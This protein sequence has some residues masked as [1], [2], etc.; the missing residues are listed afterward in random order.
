[1]RRK[2]KKRVKKGK[3]ILILLIIAAVFIAGYYIIT[4]RPLLEEYVNEELA[5]NVNLIINQTTSKKIEENNITYDKLISISKDN[6]GRIM[7][8]STQVNEMNKL[9]LDIEKEL[10]ETFL[11]TD[12]ITIE[13]PIG[14][15]LGGEFLSGRGP[16][17]KVRAVPMT[18]VYT[19]YEN[20]FDSSGINQTRHRILLNYDV[21]LKILLPGKRESTKISTGICIAETV[22]VGSVPNF[23]AGK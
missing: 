13:V 18:R 2:Y 6:D 7:S 1:M 17:L 22:I 12:H 21:S 16:C 3:F 10:L 11:N 4:M 9:K 20:Q 8:I 5:N 15:L 23:Y 19:E 14:S